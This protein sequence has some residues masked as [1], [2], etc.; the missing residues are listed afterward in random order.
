MKHRR[1]GQAAVLSEAQLQVLFERLT[2]TM[3]CLFAICYYTSCR[4][5]EALQLEAEDIL[6]E[7]I[8]FRAATT[9][10]KKTREVKLPTRLQ[11]ILHQTPLPSQGYLFPGRF[12]GHLSR[13]AA[14]LALRQVCEEMGWRGI[15]THSFRRTGITKL[16]DAAVPLRRIQARTGLSLSNLALYIDVNQND[17]DADGELL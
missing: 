17:V 7:R 11:Q 4:I 13:Q 3:R 14:D 2:P 12:K 10:T 15:S 16:H 5:G 1:N 9:K 6:G 8:I